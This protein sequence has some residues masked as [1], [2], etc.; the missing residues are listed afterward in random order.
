MAVA[1]LDGYLR[2]HAAETENVLKIYKHNNDITTGLKKAIGY[3]MK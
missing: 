1:I 3:K 2:T